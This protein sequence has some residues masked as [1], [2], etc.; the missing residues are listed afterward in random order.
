VVERVVCAGGVQPPTDA[1]YP[2]TFGEVK[3]L[4]ALAAN[5]HL[6]R[7]SWNRKLIFVLV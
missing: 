3:W 1:G 6:I 2:S 7:F 5:Q 4:A